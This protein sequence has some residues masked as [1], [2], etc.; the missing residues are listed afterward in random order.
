VILTTTS[1]F[2]FNVIQAISERRKEFEPMHLI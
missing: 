2:L 1:R